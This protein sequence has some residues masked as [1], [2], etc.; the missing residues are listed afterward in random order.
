MLVNCMK[1]ARYIGIITCWPP[2]EVSIHA[3]GTASQ[4]ATVRVRCDSVRIVVTMCEGSG[5]AS[6]CL[7]L[8]KMKLLFSRVWYHSISPHEAIIS[9]S[10]H[11]YLCTI[12][13]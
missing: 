11:L 4:D 10:L 12:I 3:G 8:L 13:C 6:N 2:L 5:R 1:Y 9:S 7:F